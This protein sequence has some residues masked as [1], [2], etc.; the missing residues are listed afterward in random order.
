[1]EITYLTKEE[2]K[3]IL[4]GDFGVKIDP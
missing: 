3:T 4:R 1:M 2:G